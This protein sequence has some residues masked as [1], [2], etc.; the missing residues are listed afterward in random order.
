VNSAIAGLY[1]H[2]GKRVRE[3]ILR[4]KRADYGEAIV[5]TLSRQLSREFGPGYTEKGL[6]RMIQF[7]ERFP[8]GEIVATIELEP[9]RRD[10]AAERSSVPMDAPEVEFTRCAH[11][12]ENLRR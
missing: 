6:W 8:N 3:D 11:V 12:A 5:A 7:A 1:W 2:I 9:H 10:P 4:E